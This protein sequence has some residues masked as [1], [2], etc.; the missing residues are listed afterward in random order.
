[1]QVQL[2]GA[3]SSWGVGSAI[4]GGQRYLLEPHCQGRSFC[5]D[6]CTSNPKQNQAQ[7][8]ETQYTQACLERDIYVTG[9]PN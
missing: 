2:L 7:Q 8:N 1:M 9:D 6:I 4:V 3:T 5:E